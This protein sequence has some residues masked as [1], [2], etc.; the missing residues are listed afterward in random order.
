MWEGS[1][2]MSF[3]VESVLHLALRVWSS[4]M[5]PHCQQRGTLAVDLKNP[6]CR[7]SVFWYRLFPPQL[8]LG[9]LESFV[10]FSFR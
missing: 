6:L 8:K 2:R 4:R 9:S 5:Y 10:R 3:G 7:P 1:R